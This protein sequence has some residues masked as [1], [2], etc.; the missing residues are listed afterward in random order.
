M[1]RFLSEEAAKLREMNFTDK[2]QYI[3]EYYKLQIIAAVVLLFVIGNIV[4]RVFINPPKRD[5][6]YIAWQAGEVLPA[7]LTELGERLRV[8]AGDQA[9]YEVSVRSYVVTGSLQ[10]DQAM[11]ARFQALVSVGDL[12]GIITTREGIVHFLQLGIIMPVHEL[13]AEIRG[14]C[15]V[16]YG[17]LY[18]RVQV[19]TFRPRDYDAYITDARAICLHGAPLLTALEIPT[20]NIYFGV[21]VNAS[22][23]YET[24]KA[25]QIIFYEGAEQCEET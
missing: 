2:R 3:W 14:L 11:A 1:R 12:H 6:L 24:A 22:R 20:E 16:L 15:P 25:L 8:I 13:M 18:D 4:N 21:L 10:M 19:I 5:Y 9:R 7:Q 23:V 17:K